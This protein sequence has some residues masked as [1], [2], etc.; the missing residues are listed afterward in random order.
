MLFVAAIL[1]LLIVL[2]LA[3]RVNIGRSVNSIDIRIHVNGTRGKSS[4]TRYIASGLLSGGNDVMAKIT[5]TEPTIIESGIVE[6]LGRSGSARVQEQFGIIRRTARKGIKRLVLEC[7]SIS[8]ELQQ[9]ESRIFKPHIYV[10]TNIRDDHRE[11]MGG[12]IEEQAESIC[13]A[14]PSNCI[15][16]TRE[17]RFLELIR[18]TAGD[19]GCTLIVAGETA[20]PDID[21]LPPGVFKENIEMALEACLAVGCDPVLARGLI[22]KAALGEKPYYRTIEAENREI[23]FLNAFAANDTGSTEELIENA[24]RNLNYRG[25]ISLLMN[26]RA[27]RP[28]RTDLFAAWIAKSTLKPECIFVC[29]THRRRAVSRLKREGVS[30]DKVVNLRKADILNIKKIISERMPGSSMLA[31]IGNYGGTGKNLLEVLN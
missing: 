4:V 15:V 10:I 20:G 2:L 24:K 30:L 12:T 14:I 3:E 25:R 7:M 31:G 21:E 26:C 8:P 1:L 22:V 19:K 16:L 18:K 11:V 27:D 6:V 5:G 23:V 29:G 28:V 13:K 9:L 17:K